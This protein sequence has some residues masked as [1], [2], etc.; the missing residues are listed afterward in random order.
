MAH[1]FKYPENNNKGIIIFTHK[2]MNYFKN[3]IFLKGT[4]LKSIIK[5]PL[6]LIERVYFKKKLKRLKKKYFIGVHWGWKTNN[7]KIPLWVDFCMSSKGNCS[8]DRDVFFIPQASRNYVPK[9]MKPDL[10]VKKNWDIIFVGKNKKLKKIQ[11]FLQEVRKIYDIGYKY[12]ILII[13]SSNKREHSRGFNKHML[14]Y[15]FENFSSK[16][17]E[18]ITVL[19]L[20]YEIGYMGMAYTPLSYLYQSSKVFSIFSPYEGGCKVIHEALLCGLP[21]VV[22][23]KLKGGGR[24]YLNKNNSVQFSNYDVA[25]KSL[26]EAVEN[27]KKYIP[28]VKKLRL[29]LGEEESLKNFKKHISELYRKKNSKFDGNLINTDSLCN[30]LP[31]HFSS[32]DDLFWINSKKLRHNTADIDNIISFKKLFAHLLNK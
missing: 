3:Y 8:F 18:N 32:K 19:K 15:Y 13:V 16:E 9:I 7:E 11:E 1:I 12:K 4:I 24:D 25:H 22:Y 14:N 17:R 20:D 26:I 30:R 27:Y 10:K 29:E 21:V 6:H 28:N 31:A 2:E 23:N 5:I